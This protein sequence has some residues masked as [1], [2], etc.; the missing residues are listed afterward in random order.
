MQQNQN[1]I[2]NPPAGNAGRIKGPQFNDRD[3]LNDALAT[4]KLLTDNFNVMAREAS[5]QSLHRDVTAM[6][7]ETHQCAREL[8]NLMFRKGWY[9]LEPEDAQKLQQTYQQFSDYKTQFAY[10]EQM[11]Q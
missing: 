3:L 4:E 10:P 9:K 6:L 1:I 11:M 5:H 2:A 8:F 7:M